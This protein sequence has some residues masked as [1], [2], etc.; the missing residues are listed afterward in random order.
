MGWSCINDMGC[1]CKSEPDWEEQPIKRIV[2]DPKTGKVSDDSYY[3]S[4]GKCKRDPKACDR[5]QTASERY[6][7][8]PILPAKPKNTTK[9]VDPNAPKKTKR[10]GLQSSFLE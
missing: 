6:P 10:I 1:Y 2:P 3:F 5:H 7:A 4:G 8:S 9:P